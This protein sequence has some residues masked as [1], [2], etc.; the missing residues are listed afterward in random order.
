M[1]LLRSALAVKAM[2][3]GGGLRRRWVRVRKLTVCV[4]SSAA[5]HPVGFPGISDPNEKKI[6]DIFDLEPDQP[7]QFVLISFFK[8]LDSLLFVFQPGIDFRGVIGF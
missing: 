8:V 5:L 7:Y 1:I 2:H 6:K 4:S 3:R